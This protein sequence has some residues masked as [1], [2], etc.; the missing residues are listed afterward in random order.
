M[1]AR[2]LLSRCEQRRDR[3]ARSGN[4]R[5][6]GAG[7]ANEIISWKRKV[8]PLGSREWRQGSVRHQCEIRDLAADEKSSLR[9]QL[10]ESDVSGVNCYV[11]LN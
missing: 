4:G 9:R 10:V 6:W 2:M 3:L 5:L 8:P 1:Q 7:G 11:T